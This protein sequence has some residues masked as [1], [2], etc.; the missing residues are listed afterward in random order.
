MTSVANG[1]V[2]NLAN[3]MANGIG[4]V[5]TVLINSTKTINLAGILSDGGAGTLA[6][7]QSGSGTT[8]LLNSNTYTGPT[9]I[10]A[11]T[12]QIGNGST[13][14]TGG[15]SNVIVT[16]TGTLA[17]NLLDGSTFANS[18]ALNSAN[19]SVKVIGSGTNTFSGNISGA[20]SFNQSGA[21]T[22]I[23]TGQN[24]YT[25]PTKVG[26][27]TLKIG[28]AS[29][30]ASAGT[31]IFNLGT[32]GSLVVINSTNPTLANNAIN[33]LGGVGTR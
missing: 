2:G 30:A 8:I 24:T 31:G 32:G 4:G 18:I 28:T 9:T 12:L 19:G 27:G 29:Q 5:G 14:S 22:T 15:A 16:N 33:N 21:G 13:Q 11:G 17:V 20:G 26:T 7:T 25:G 10:T 23:L 3:S 6:L 1:A